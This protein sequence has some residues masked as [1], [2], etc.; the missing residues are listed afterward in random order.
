[1]KGGPLWAEAREYVWG[2]LEEALRS[3]SQSFADLRIPDYEPLAA[4]PARASAFDRSSFYSSSH[5]KR[6][7][8]TLQSLS[9]PVY[10][11]RAQQLSS[12]SPGDVLVLKETMKRFASTREDAQRVQL[13]H[14][15]H[16]GAAPGEITDIM[17]EVESCMQQLNVHGWKLKL[18]FEFRD[19]TLVVWLISCA[20]GPEHSHMVF[21]LVRQVG[22][23]RD[24]TCRGVFKGGSDGFHLRPHLNIAPDVVLHPAK[25]HCAS[26]YP[27]FVVELEVGNRSVLELRK[28]LHR[29]FVAHSNAQCAL[30]I[31]VHKETWAASAALWCRT[32]A[33]IELHDF[34]DFGR[35]VI[36]LRDT[37]YWTA[38]L[39]DGLSGLTTDVIRQKRCT[40]TN[41]DWPEA[42]QTDWNRHPIVTVPAGPFVEVVKN[43]SRHLLRDVHDMQLDLA[44]MLAEAALE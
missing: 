41:A 10:A 37:N 15:R 26:T 16:V 18:D 28:H 19:S 27:C 8:D 43:E 13:L 29:Y 23:W 21:E 39:A 32:R 6:T 33:G 17:L 4:F 44:R 3:L 40:P 38:E 30:G 24:S 11:E 20:T 42:S 35:I 1:M 2:P 9:A 22:A 36:D 12:I 31:K 7:M 25:G 5:L 14:V 34:W